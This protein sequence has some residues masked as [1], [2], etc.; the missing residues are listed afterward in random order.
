M[1]L[2]VISLLFASACYLGWRLFDKPRHAL[3]WS[4]AFALAAGQY[5]LNLMQ[6]RIPVYEVYWLAVNVVSS[7][8][9]FT[10][11]AGHR[12][13]LQ[14]T[15]PLPLAFLV[16]A[17][18]LLAQIVF[19]LLIPRIDIRVALAPAFA[20]MAF[21]HVAW[22]LH[23]YGPE[24]RLAQVAAASVYLLFGLAQ[25][26]AAGIALQLGNE[27]SQA[28][29]DA[30][31]LVNFALMPTFFV[32]TGITVIFLLG[33]DLA[34][35]LWHLAVT[36]SLTALSNRR[37]FMQASA[38]LLAQAQR[39]RRALTLITADLDFFKKINDSFGHAVGD[40]AL[41]HFS[42]TLAGVVRGE[43][44]AGRV[45]GEEFAVLLLGDVKDA[46]QVVARLRDTLLQ[47]PIYAVGKVMPLSAS[48]GI[49]EWQGEQEVEGL[50]IRADRALYAAKAA[51]R[52]TVVLAPRDVDSDTLPT[53]A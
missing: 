47:R 32:A 7:L 18:L 22:I 25:G 5:G 48:F 29:R 34:T 52:D 27:P 3:I 8:L 36:D 53:L 31:N 33:T 10:A 11:A 4:G 9:V 20:C 50:M 23:R 6:D 46:Q 43:D 1:T 49:A 24:P 42:S 16:V 17:G 15:T 21:L 41:V 35:R 39:Q 13:R 2:V 38:R 19:T 44:V 45:G 37:G 51:G 26:V 14:L 12:V 40:D 28:Q 30:Y